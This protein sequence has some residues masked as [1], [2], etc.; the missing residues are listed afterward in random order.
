MANHPITT[1]N[2]NISFK[3]NTSIKSNNNE[4]EFLLFSNGNGVIHTS[5]NLKKDIK[6]K[7]D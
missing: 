6:G 3:L 2:T 4:K 1:E 5:S 7:K